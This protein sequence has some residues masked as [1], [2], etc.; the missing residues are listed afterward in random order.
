MAGGSKANRRDIA[1]A[2]LLTERTIEEAADRAGVSARTLKNWLAE[3]DFCAA[4]RAARRQLVEGAVGRLQEASGKAVD[5]LVALLDCGHA[6]TRARAAMGILERSVRAIETTDLMERLEAMERRLSEMAKG[7]VG[8][9]EP[10]NP[11]EDEQAGDGAAAAD[12]AG[13]AAHSADDE[14]P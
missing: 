1:I 5:A 14:P 7:K 10:A 4:Y 11:D 9:G 13:E 3:P 12:A 2:A 8:D 6:P